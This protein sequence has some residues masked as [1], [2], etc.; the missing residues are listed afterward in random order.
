M[1]MGKVV[2]IRCSVKKGSPKKKLKVANFI[3]GFGLEGDL[4]AG[5]DG[6]Q[7]SF[8]GIETFRVI[9]K[10]EVKG[11]CTNKFV[12]NITT[13]NIELWNLTVGTE[14]KI[15]ETI[16]RVTK[17]GK[18]CF[19]GCPVREQEGSCIMLNQVVFAN[20]LQGGKIKIGD[21]IKILKPSEVFA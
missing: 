17:V 15:G 20:V 8:M 13:E 1:K 6:R 14:L 12:E 11:Y 19:R 5:K 10:S 21:S 9:Q 7:V 4:H 3:Q 18:E 2:E 16:M